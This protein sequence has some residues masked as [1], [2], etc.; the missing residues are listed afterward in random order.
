MYRD[1]CELLAPVARGA[2]I[3]YV[4]DGSR[5]VR[6]NDRAEMEILRMTGCPRMAIINSKF[7]D[8]DYTESWKNEFRRTFNAFRV[9]SAH[10][11]NYA[12][13]LRLL[14][15]LK[16]IDQDWQPALERVTS[17][18]R[19]DWTRRNLLSAQLIAGLIEEAV[20]H[21][22]T[23]RYAERSGEQALKG[24]LLAAYQ[25]D[26]AALEREAH[27]KIR[28]LFK[29]NIFNI[30]MPEQSIL[31]HD[32]FDSRTWQVLGLTPKQLAAAAAACGGA[33]GACLDL[34]AAGL[35]FGVFTALG[36]IAAAGSALAPRRR[37]NRQKH[38][39][40]ETRPPPP[41]SSK[42]SVTPCQ[43]FPGNLPSKEAAC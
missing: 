29:H 41:A 37:R 36:S 22:A 16:G 3:I 28:K 31:Q 17:A 24:E 8:T 34:A 18:Y 12:E 6:K 5:P 9:F 19:S 40:S 13:R 11:A 30:D 43:R 25:R 14:E 33:L 32:L 15:S 26:I 21:T 35:T 1:E 23:M 38:P 10:K 2:G 42:A 4:V 27:R 7:D 39:L 20:G